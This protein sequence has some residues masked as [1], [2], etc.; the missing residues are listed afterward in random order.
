MAEG[1]PILVTREL[2]E[3]SRA[4]ARSLGLEPIER[5][6]IVVKPTADPAALADELRALGPGPAWAFTSPKAVEALRPHWSPLADSAPAEA[7]AVGERTAAGVAELGL[8]PRLPAEQT[9]SGLAQA[10]RAADDI[11]G[12]IHFCGNRARPE[13]GQLLQAAGLAYF[14]LVVYET[15]S[16][17]LIEP[18]PSPLKATL[19]CSPSAV[20]SFLEQRLDALQPGPFFAIGPTTAAACSASGLHASYPERPDI[21]ALLDWAA[22][23]LQG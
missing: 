8:S 2:D 15:R 14:P 5:P 6:L 3:E 4:H 19:F 18:L 13:L 9:A 11:P 12:V 16:R 23:Q 1:M 20:N 21:K 7:F 10:I 17:P 22:H